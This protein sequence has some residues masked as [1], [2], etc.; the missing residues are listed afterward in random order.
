VFNPLKRVLLGSPL[1]SSEASH[2]RLTKVTGLAVLSSDALSSVAYATDAMLTVLV[3]AGLVAVSATR[4]LALL[5]AALLVIVTFSYR[6]TIHAY[7]Q[8]GGAYIVAKDNLGVVPG[9]IAATALLI[10]YVL[11]VSVSV[12]AGVAAVVSAAPA[13][14]QYR[15]VLAVAFIGIVAWGNLRGVRD[16][17]RIFAVPTYLFIVSVI[18]LL[19]VAAGRALVGHFPAPSALPLQTSFPVQTEE[20][21]GVG[22][23]VLLHAFANG[24]T[25]MT[26]VEAI[27]NGIPAFEPPEA[28]NAAKTL[29]IMVSIL[30]TMFLGISLLGSALH[31]VPQEQETVLSQIARAVFGGRN[32][33]YFVLQAATILILVLAANTSYADFPRLASILARDGFAPTQFTH[34]GDRLAF[35]NG[36]IVLTLFA[37]ALVVI[38]GG[39]V[40]RLI[41]LYAVGVFLSFTLSQAGMVM[42][43]RRLRDPGWR[44]RMLMNAL[45]AF[46]TAAVLVIFVITKFREGAWVV[47][48]MIPV[49]VWLFLTIARHYQQA[50]KELS[51]GGDEPS[52]DRADVMIVIVSGL[53]RET[54]EALRYAMKRCQDVR[55]VHVDLDAAEVADLRRDWAQWGGGAPLDVLDSPYRSFVA[56]VLEYVARVEAEGPDRVITIVLPEV[57]PRR[58]WQT[59][60]HNRWSVQLRAA[61]ISR[62]RVT[63]LT[64]VAWPLPD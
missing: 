4:P 37:V 53:S 62:P 12:A 19:V 48:V 27:S 51:L 16:S 36:I 40:F 57:I 38:F 47:A 28:D 13:I 10:D 41:P 35:S 7:P 2:E 43:W 61:L 26:G 52:P 14:S 21:G 60:L 3:P 42:H 22:L 6:Q 32:V 46:A 58:W 1:L 15:V 24:C 44:A 20:M 8:G 55:A 29:L 63:V 49:G 39:S 34:R 30:L 64:T 23:F 54:V 33:A 9:L 31:V 59:L 17:G 45:G 18:I 11:T 50:R 5:I 56:P 25:A